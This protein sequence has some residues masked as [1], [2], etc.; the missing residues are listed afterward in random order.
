MTLIASLGKSI[1]VRQGLLYMP[2][3][4]V[5]VVVLDLVFLC[6]TINPFILPSR[7]LVGDLIIWFYLMHPYM[8]Y[9]I[10]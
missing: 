5:V 2:T 7:N 9:A 10:I 8:A 1:L 3:C 6:V 4:N